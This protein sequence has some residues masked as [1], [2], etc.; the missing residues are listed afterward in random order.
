MKSIKL[1]REKDIYP[2]NTEINL[3]QKEATSSSASRIIPLAI[4][5][6]LLVFVIFRFGVAEGIYGKY[7]LDSDIKKLETQLSELQALTKDYDTAMEEYSRYSYY[8]YNEEEIVLYDRLDIVDI[9]GQLMMPAG[10]CE[11]YKIDGNI[12]SLRIR[13]ITLD[14][15][16]ALMEQLYKVAGVENVSL[17][18]ATDGEEV[19][20][21]MD[22][23]VTFKAAGED[24][25]QELPTVSPE[26]LAGDSEVQP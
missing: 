21:G 25:K 12:L 2:Q 22:I 5:L 14:Q 13:E 8:K 10:V 11:Q 23:A 9:V 6:I 3:L 1:R 17:M 18:S 7:K 24:L 16:S 26:A 4:F 20:A 19:N 15:A